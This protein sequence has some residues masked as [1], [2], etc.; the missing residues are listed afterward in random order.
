[1][2]ILESRTATAALECRAGGFPLHELSYARGLTHLGEA[3]VADGLGFPLLRRRISAGPWFDAV[4]PSPYVAPT[5]AQ[6]AALSDVL[7]ELVSIVGVI[8]PGSKQNW[9]AV[10]NVVMAKEHYVFEPSRPLELSPRARRHLTAGRRRWRFELARGPA[11]ADE[12]ANM[13]ARVADF[14][15]FAG[16]AVDFPA[17]HFRQLAGAPWG[18][19][20]TAVG[21]DGELG[22]VACGALWTDELHLLHLNVSAEGLRSAASYVLMSGITGWCSDTG[23]TLF[24]GSR[25]QTGTAGLA[26]FKARW[27]NLRLPSH[28]IRIVVRPAAYESLCRAAETPS[29]F[30]P[31][32]R[33][34]AG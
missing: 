27:T 33:T 25:P 14:R 32:Y 9:A 1:M 15:G 29:G 31:A 26:R 11:V 7:P 4:L 24:L 6:V 17:V 34:P 23:R 8:R 30:F 20:F 10:S 18:V 16:S 19:F 13:H 21:A 28:L 12:A 2:R 3:V 5:P 22:A